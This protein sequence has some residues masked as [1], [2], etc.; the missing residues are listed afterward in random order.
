VM[1][2]NAVA[3]LVTMLVS[4]AAGAFGPIETN[5]ARPVAALNRKSPASMSRGGE[6]DSREGQMQAIDD[7]RHEDA[8]EH[9]GDERAGRSIASG[10]GDQRPARGMREHA[11][12]DR[13]RQ[14]TPRH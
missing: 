11:D 3:P 12:R 2:R 13:K 6:G 5:S 7:W 14:Q 10:D 9:A 4:K 1:I 8:D